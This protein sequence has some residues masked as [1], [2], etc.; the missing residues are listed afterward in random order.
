MADWTLIAEPD[1]RLMRAHAGYDPK[2]H[3]QICQRYSNGCRR[4]AT[5]FSATA[6]RTLPDLFLC[7][8]HMGAQK[9]SWKS[10]GVSWKVVSPG[11]PVRAA[12]EKANAKR[13]RELHLE[14]ARN[15][16]Y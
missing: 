7:G 14:M 6:E 8:P 13:D 11:D 10:E 16:G 3:K 1:G 2:G 4:D 9:R 12:F 15:L 5:F